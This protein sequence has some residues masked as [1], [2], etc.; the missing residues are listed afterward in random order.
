[1]TGGMSSSRG[2]HGHQ[3]TK[4]IR[5]KD[6]RYNKQ[7]RILWNQAGTS[8]AGDKRGG[9]QAWRG[10]SVAATSVEATSTVRDKRGGNRGV[11][12]DGAE[13]EVG[14]CQISQRRCVRSPS[15]P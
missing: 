12:S 6:K 14:S 10:T 4:G 9:G 3:A 7:Q 5:A 2:Q 15:K 11:D 1:M 13:T 8:A